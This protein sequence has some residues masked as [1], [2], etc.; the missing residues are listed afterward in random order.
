MRFARQAPAVLAAAVAVAVVLPGGPFLVRAQTPTVSPAPSLEPSL[1]SAPSDVPSSQPSLSSS[2]SQEPSD[3]PSSSPSQEPSLSSAPTTG[4]VQGGSYA[5]CGAVADGAPPCAPNSRCI[6]DGNKGTKCVCND[7]FE[8]DAL[9][10]GTGCN[11]IDECSDNLLNDCIAVSGGSICVDTEGSYTCTCPADTT[12]GGG[13]TDTIMVSD[14]LTSSTGG[15]GKTPASGGSGCPATTTAIYSAADYSD[16]EP[17]AEAACEAACISP[18][19]LCFNDYLGAGGTTYSCACKIGFKGVGTSQVGCTRLAP[20]VGEQQ[21]LGEASAKIDEATNTLTAYLNDKEAYEDAQCELF[22]T[23]STCQALTADYAEALA[24]KTL[25]DNESTQA[26]DYAATMEAAYQAAQAKNDFGA[27]RDVNSV[28]GRLEQ[29]AKK[30]RD[31]ALTVASAA[32]TAATTAGS[33]AT[34]AKTAMDNV[35]DSSDNCSGAGTDCVGYAK[36]QESA[37]QGAYDGAKT[38]AENNNLIPEILTPDTANVYQDPFDE[39]N[40][41][42]RDGDLVPD[43]FDACPTQMGLRR[44]RM[45]M[46]IKTESSVGG[47]GYTLNE[48]LGIANPGPQDFCPSGCP[49]T[50]AAGTI[51]DTDGDGIP[52]CEDRCPFVDGI[53]YN[54]DWSFDVAIADLDRNL[55][56][57]GCPDFGKSCFLFESLSSFGTPPPFH[58]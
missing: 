1:S 4:F 36:T 12:K 35:C 17:A 39:F 38:D 26:A 48:N 42:D 28:E 52:D 5:D 29:A 54:H 6:D 37:A 45:A 46:G 51:L 10:A 49:E 7:G 53:P 20:V 13:T 25:A 11:D 2:P 44:D 34:T 47:V 43:Q 27:D 41:A 30:A 22:N 31:D 23:N 14:A 18:D 40:Y 58:T 55:D 16:S 19:A 9:A 8:G 50:D 21:S 3:S 33:T 24:L 56:Y 57:H 32:S 15:D